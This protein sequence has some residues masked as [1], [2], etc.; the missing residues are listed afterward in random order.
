MAVMTDTQTSRVTFRSVFVVREFRVLFSG[1]LMFILGFE[2]EIL[3]L[4]VLVYAQTRSGFLASVAFTT[5]FMPQAVGG[6]FLTSLA[7]RLPPRLVITA[8]LLARAAPG[9]VIGLWPALPVPVM[10]AMVAVAAIAT[11]VFIAATSGLLP[12]VLDADHYILGRSIFSMTD[13]GIQIAGLGIGGGILAVLSAR[14]LLL[15][16]GVSLMVAAVVMRAGLRLRP[17]R[18]EAT[19]V[20]GTVRATI[21]GNV[22]LLTLRPVRGLLLAQWLPVWFVTGAEALII[23]YAVSLGDPPGA[24]GP[25]LAAVP[26][27]M[28]LG[29]LLVGRFCP[30][31]RRER[32]AFPLALLLGAPLLM[33]VFRP[34]PL[35]AGVALFISGCGY[36]YQL[37][38]QQAFLDSLPA[39]LRG[40]AFGLRTTGTMGGQGLVPS[41]IGGIAAALGPAVA[42][43][44]AG[45]IAMLTALALHGP[46]S[47]H[48]ASGGSR[49]TG[50][51]KGTPVSPLNQDT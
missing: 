44:M 11:P 5:G 41:A 42:M 21:A 34:P 2:F 30:L 51:P 14:W 4:S 20:R 16:A 47:G 35:I 33:L 19:R 45:T 38:I 48:A 49:R 9:L 13:S 7:D 29:D 26:G 6:A 32:L 24:A 3:G 46:L 28:L 18:S 43:A 12:D 22:E 50:S 23:P 15:A 27:G 17:A 39:R 8:G 40:Q 31:A 37:G 36:A 1:M 10:L 25:L